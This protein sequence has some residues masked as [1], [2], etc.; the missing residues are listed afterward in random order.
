DGADH[1]V[2]LSEGSL[3]AK[4]AGELRHATKSHHHQGVDRL[5]AG[6]VVSGRSTLDDLPEAIELPDARFVLGVQWHPEADVES[7]V[8]AA[9]VGVAAGARIVD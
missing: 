1:D 9:L 6:L 7:S 2:L 4:A 5:G 3:A 8:V